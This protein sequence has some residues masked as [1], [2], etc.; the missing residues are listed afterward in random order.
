[1]KKSF[2]EF[3]KNK[4]FQYISHRN[5]DL[6]KGEILLKK[7]NM[8]FTMGYDINGLDSM[9]D[10]NIELNHWITLVDSSIINSDKWIDSIRDFKMKR[11]INKIK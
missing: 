4:G 3:V 6:N 9:I 11:I 8:Y 2:I 10:N 1:M 5:I 7:R